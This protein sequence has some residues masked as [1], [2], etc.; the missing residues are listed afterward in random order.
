MGIDLKM[1]F[2][3]SDINVGGLML[4][5]ATSTIFHLCRGSQFYLWWKPEQPEKTTNPPNV[6]DKLYHIMLYQVHLTM[7]GIQAHN[8][9][10][11]RH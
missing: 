7:S 9:G 3:F 8:C 6:T 11:D 4:F 2:I 10:G 1:L 5:N